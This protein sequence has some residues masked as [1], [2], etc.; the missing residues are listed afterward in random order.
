M[1]FGNQSI[2]SDQQNSY[3]SKNKL[4]CIKDNDYSEKQLFLDKNRDSKQQMIYFME[5]DFKS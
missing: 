5:K 3:R 4:N 1:D 2:G